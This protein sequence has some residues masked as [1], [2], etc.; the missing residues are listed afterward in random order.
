MT[1]AMFDLYPE[2]KGKAPGING[3]ALEFQDFEWVAPYHDGAIRYYK[4]A[5]VWNDA[6]Q[7]HND[8]LVA[9]QKALAAAWEALKAENPD[10]W[11]EAW[12]EARRKALKDGG[13]KVFF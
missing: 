2:Y 10:N 1:K 7:A 4:E 13:F 5:G 9:R 11:E 6:A 12:A 8:E 3:W